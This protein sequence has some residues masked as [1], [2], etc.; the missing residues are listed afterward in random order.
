M[1]GLYLW[2]GVMILF[3]NFQVRSQQLIKGIVVDSATFAA[4]PYVNIQVKNSLVSV[5]T[6]AK[7][8][9]SII[10]TKNDTLIF[11]LLGY[12]RIEQ[13]L[14]DYEPSLIRMAEQA[15]MLLPVVIHDTRM[16]ANPYHGMFSEQQANLKKR[17]PFYYHRSRKDK[18]KAAFWK[19]EVLRVQTYVDVIINDP[20][21]KKELITKFSVTEKVYYELLAEFNAQHEEVMYYLTRVELISL[22]TKFFEDRVGR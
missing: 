10:A 11:T 16:N 18:L 8:N 6:D 22:L 14:L 2:V 20:A 9:F 4:L 21:T 13:P 1:K 12:K 19:E 17:I 3:V 5:T 7:G 15:I